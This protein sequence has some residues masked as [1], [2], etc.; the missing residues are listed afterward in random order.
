MFQSPYDHHQGVILKYFL[1]EVV[2]IYFLLLL[3]R[4]VAACLQLMTPHHGQE[5]ANKF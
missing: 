2:K 3:V 4:D 1:Y 5:I